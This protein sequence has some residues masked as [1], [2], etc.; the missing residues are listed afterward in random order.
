MPLVRGFSEKAVST[1]IRR[2]VGAGRPH[3][4]AVAIAMST[5]REAAKKKG[6]LG[7]AVAAL[8]PR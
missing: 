7:A 4:Q 1:N 8:K 5:A 3:A 2:E 6:K